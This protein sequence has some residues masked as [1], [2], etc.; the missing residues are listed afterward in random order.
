VS[1]LHDP[2]Q[3]AEAPLQRS[4]LQPGLAPAVPAGASAQ[5]P[6]VAPA[7]PCEPPLQAS[8]LPEHALLQQR[9]SEQKV[10]AQLAP[11]AQLCP[12]FDRHAPAALQVET[13][14]QVSRSSPFATVV[15]LPGFAAQ[16]WHA[17]LQAPVQQ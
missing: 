4:G 3:L 5:V 9:L 7:Q 14:V 10:D 16:V 17:A 11:V 12:F 8:Q 13:P 15:Q 2:G 6:L 1:W